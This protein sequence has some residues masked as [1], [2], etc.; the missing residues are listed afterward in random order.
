MSAAPN[1]SID[2]YFDLVGQPAPGGPS[3]A[4]LAR[5]QLGHIMAIPFEN[6]NPLAGLTVPLDIPALLDKFTHRRGGYCF[7]HN[8]LYR[9]ALD[10]L[11]YRTTPLLARV[12]VNA[13]PGV[14]TPRTHMLLLVEVEG[15]R[16]LS[17]T[18]FGKATPTAPLRLVPGEAQSTPHGVYRLV[19][20]GDAGDSFLLE[21]DAGDG[22]APLYAFE[23][24]PAY[25]VDFEMSNWYVSTHPA[26][27]FTRDLIA[28]RT[29]ANGR[30]V[31]HNARYSFYAVDGTATRKELATPAALVHLLENTFGLAAGS[32]PGLGAK[33]SEIV[34]P[35]GEGFER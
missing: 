33:L 21:T 14:V 3:L 15:E 2:A 1:T 28:V 35:R 7:E 34:S 32:V 29:V 11:G 27:H 8:L 25:P 30:H 22:W 26:S 17:D 10:T 31:L 9:H 5:L 6:L 19:P 24:R 20:E 18:G 12:R 23:S 13:A 4:G 16:W